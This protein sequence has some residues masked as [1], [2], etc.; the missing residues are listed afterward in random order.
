MSVYLPKRLTQ[1]GK[2]F[3][4][5]KLIRLFTDSYQ[6]FNIV[7]ET[8]FREFVAAL[9]PT[10]QLPSRYMISKTIIPALYEKC[11]NDTKEILKDAKKVC[12]T[13][14]CWTSINMESFMAVTIHFLT[15][16]FIPVS[17]L[18]EAASL[19]VQHTAINLSKELK[20]VLTHWNVIDKILMIVSDNAANVK[21]AIKNEMGF[22][23]FGCFA[24]TINLVVTDGL[25]EEEV[26]RIIVKVKHIV[27]H[28]KRS[29]VATQKLLAYQ[30]Q[31]NIARPLK[32]LQDVPTR[33]NSSYYMLERFIVLE[34]AIKTTMAL[35]N[36]DGANQLTVN[37][38]VVIK[39]LCQ[40][41][42]PFEKVTKTISG[43][44]YL[45]A[46][47]VIPL[48]NGLFSVYKNLLDKPFSGCM[49]NLLIKLNKSLEDRFANLENSNTLSMSTFLDPRFKSIPFKDKKNADIAKKNIIS[50][51][52]EKFSHEQQF[53]VMENEKSSSNK[54]SSDG[55]SDDDIWAEFDR[56]AAVFQPV[57][58]STS[59][60]IIEVQRFLDTDILD[61]KENPLDW[62]NKN[63]YLFPHLALVAQERLS[64]IATSVP[65]ERRFSKAGQIVTERRSRLS[66][67]KTQ[68]LLFLNSNLKVLN[69]LGKD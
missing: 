54:K 42:K 26:S 49:K 41:L 55:D 9:N 65:C 25:K 38:W 19:P 46:S 13:T 47:L 52:A 4:D 18:L 14:D 1:K 21:A 35:T 67:R 29:H 53:N 31:Q 5:D 11:S 22:K 27:G 44:D 43:E 57:G 37:E 12:I 3:I 28:F 17:L 10:Y 36:M 2:Q 15:D 61:R 7:E 56:E 62:W 48:A 58:T 34:D 64:A 24:H 69:L 32:I 68:M 51:V 20:R 23:H 66:N 63:K 39:E 6:P 16:N 59:K 30:Q 8:A 60:A 50:L 45:T 33:W 40:A